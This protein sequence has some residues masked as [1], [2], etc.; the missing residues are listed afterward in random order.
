MCIVTLKVILAY[1][2]VDYCTSFLYV[3]DPAVSIMC[4]CTDSNNVMLVFIIHP[5][6]N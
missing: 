1:F 6:L 5:S 3:H 4:R 2:K